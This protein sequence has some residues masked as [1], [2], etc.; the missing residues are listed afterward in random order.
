MN[1][2]LADDPRDGSLKRFEDG[3]I[4]QVDGQH[5]RHA[6]G[7]SDY[8]ERGSERPARQMFEGQCAK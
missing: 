1:R 7:N 3:L 8:R 5:G 6:N 4:R 2:G